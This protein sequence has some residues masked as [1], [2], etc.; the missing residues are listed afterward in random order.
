MQRQHN[1]PSEPCLWTDTPANK[2]NYPVNCVSWLQAKA[3]TTF[4]GARLPT[5]AEWEFAARSRGKAHI[6][7][8][9]NDEA[10]AC[11]GNI[12]NCGGVLAPV[13]SFEGD[14]TARRMRHVRER[15]GVGGR[16]LRE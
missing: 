10:T 6:Y 14:R 9:G 13:C 16:R 12:A 3:F 5:D 4:V 2:E 15:V 8:W 7:A 11:I 1:G